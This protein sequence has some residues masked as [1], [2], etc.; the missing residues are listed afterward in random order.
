MV[1]AFE[2]HPTPTPRVC[3]CGAVHNPYL[4][5]R[6]AKSVNG[7]LVRCHACDV[8]NIGLVTRRVFRDVVQR[9]IQR[10]GGDTLMVQTALDDCEVY[11]RNRLGE[12]VALVN[13]CDRFSKPID[14]S[15]FADIP[16]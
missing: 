6:R 14:A 16:Y 3:A 13:A 4:L 11:L 12:A 7:V 9:Y 2:S 15:A 8:H 5:D 10:F 1:R